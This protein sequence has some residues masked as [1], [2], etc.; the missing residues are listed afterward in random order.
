MKTREA[1][2]LAERISKMPL[3]DFVGLMDVMAERAAQ[4]KLSEV[5]SCLHDAGY[6][7]RKR[8]QHPSPVLMSAR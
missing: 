8:Q 1:E 3:A 5:Q 7:A 6:A 2:R 4:L